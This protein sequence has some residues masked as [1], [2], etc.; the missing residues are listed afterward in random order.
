MTSLSPFQKREGCDRMGKILRCDS[1]RDGSLEVEFAKEEDAQRALMMTSFSYSVRV[2][3]RKTLTNIPISVTPHRTKNFCKGVITCFDLKDTSEEEIVEGLSTSGVV[4]AYRIRSRRGDEGIATNSIILTFNSTEL[5]TEVTVGYLRV[6][7]RPYIPNPMRCFRCQRFGHTKTYCRNRLTCAKCASTEHVDEDC[8]ATAYRCVNCGDGQNSHASFDRSCPAL[9]KEKEINSI[10]ATRNVSFKEAREIYNASHPS[11]SYA[12]KA[13]VPVKEARTSFDSM[14]AA[15]LLT[16]LRSF[17][18]TVVTPAGM[19]VA[20]AAAEPSAAPV[21]AVTVPSDIPTGRVNVQVTSAIAPSSA[22]TIATNALE[23]GGWE[24]ARG[25]RERGRRPSPPENAKSG[26]THS[27]PRTAVMEALRRGEE[28]RKAR[29]AKRARL[30]EKAKEARHSPV[31]EASPSQTV[32]DTTGAVDRQTVN[33]ALMGPPPLPPLPP[34]RR[35]A[36]PPPPAVLAT[37]DIRPPPEN[38]PAVPRPSKPPSAPS[39]PIKRGLPLTGSPTDH[40]HPK[41]K[42]HSSSVHARASSADGRL[43]QGGS[44]RARVRYGDSSSDASEV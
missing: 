11:I 30:A 26:S 44:V 17:G 6:K 38:P 39:R 33:P 3:G 19:P 15:Q 27:P 7:V 18:L 40:P 10:K 4:G 37:P 36:P 24:R 8:D 13:K 21:S 25:R 28:E 23:E 1:L 42:H 35:P 22:D 16:I 2:Q 9:A 41:V 14:S 31:T 32:R 20:T 12:Q 5:P 43:Y 34:H 29:E